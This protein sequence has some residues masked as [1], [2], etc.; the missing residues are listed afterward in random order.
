MYRRRRPLLG[1]AIV[2]GAASAGT[3]RAIQKQQTQATLSA[4]QQEIQRQ[5]MEKAEAEQKHREEKAAWEKEKADQK[6]K[7][8]RLAWEKQMEA[9]YG[10]IPGGFPGGPPGGPP[11]YAEGGHGAGGGEKKFCPSCGNQ[12]TL[13]ANF[14]TSCGN[15]LGGL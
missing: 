6:A 14:C 10:Q 7:E 12:Y 13:G 5:E 9:K 11:A 3:N 8:E 15:K 4:Q 2:M 1:A